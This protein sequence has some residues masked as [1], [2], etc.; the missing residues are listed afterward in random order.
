MEIKI[1]DVKNIPKMNKSENMKE[2]SKQ[3][4]N[5]NK[6]IINS[7][8]KNYRVEH[9]EQYNG[10]S[11]NYFRGLRIKVIEKY[12]SKCANPY[13]INHGEFLND[14]RCLQIDHVNNDGFKERNALTNSS[15]LKKVLADKEGN[16]QLLCANCNW[17]KRHINFNDKKRK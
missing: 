12:S 9:R 5:D 13:N 7:K 3:Y 4:Y 16:Y 1:I 6:K 11:K 17:I 2:Y 14:I 10:Y 15:Y 8:I